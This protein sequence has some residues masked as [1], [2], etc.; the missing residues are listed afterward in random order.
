MCRMHGGAASQVRNA[1]EARLALEKLLDP[2]IVELRKL[3]KGG[4][5]P[6]AVK[7]QAIDSILDRNGLKPVQK[8]EDITPAERMT[9]DERLARIRQLHAQLF[10]DETI[11]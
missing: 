11:Q 4:R 10:P 2:A 9:P 8:V 3:L 6:S 7:R 1:A 5:I